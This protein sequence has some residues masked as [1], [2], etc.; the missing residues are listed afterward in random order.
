MPVPANNLH[1]TTGILTTWHFYKRQLVAL[2]TVSTLL[3]VLTSLAPIDGGDY[4]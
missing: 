2:N 3:K 1:L 4:L